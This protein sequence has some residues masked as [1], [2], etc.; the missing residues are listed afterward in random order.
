VG[1]ETGNQRQRDRRKTKEV[2]S[3]RLRLWIAWLVLCQQPRLGERF[4]ERRVRVG[5]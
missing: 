2:A 5:S 3:S 1:D 4:A